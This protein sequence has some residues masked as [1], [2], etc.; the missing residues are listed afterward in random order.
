MKTRLL[1]IAL[2]FGTLAGVAVADSLEVEFLNRKER[3]VC[4]YANI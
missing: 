3:K 1:V 4:V 2:I